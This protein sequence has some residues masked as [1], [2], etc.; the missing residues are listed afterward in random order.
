VHNVH[1]KFHKVVYRHNSGE[2]ENIHIILQHFYS[3][4]SIPNFI[5]IALVLWEILQKTFWSLFFWTQCT[6]ESKSRRNK[7]RYSMDEKKI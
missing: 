1:F 5:K 3:G 7:N 6:R 2:V 4:N